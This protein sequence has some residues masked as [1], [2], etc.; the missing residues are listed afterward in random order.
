M[1]I[2]TGYGYLVAVI[3]F[4]F[5]LASEL[6]T[7][8]IFHDEQRYQTDLVPLGISFLLS[9]MVIRILD[10]FFQS[11]RKKNEGTFFVSKDTIA[12]TDHSLFFIQFKYWPLLLVLLGI[13]VILY[14]V[15]R[16]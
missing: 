2:S 14:Q 12:K 4:L 16:S 8:G 13:A 15:F 7:E 6:V 5:S 3:A 1:I 9:A 11:K 10:R